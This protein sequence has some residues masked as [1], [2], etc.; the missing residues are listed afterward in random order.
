LT[1]PKEFI[2]PKLADSLVLFR[3]QD[4]GDVAI[5]PLNTDRF[6]LGWSSIAAKFCLA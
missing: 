5:V 3:G 1:E 4:H 6:V 2:D